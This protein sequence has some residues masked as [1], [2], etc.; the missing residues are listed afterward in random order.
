[1][2]GRLPLPPT[3]PKRFYYQRGELVDYLEVDHEGFEKLSRGHLGLTTDSSGRL[4]ALRPEALR[5]LEALRA[6]G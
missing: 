1:M 2:K 4:I 6:A 5:E 3:G